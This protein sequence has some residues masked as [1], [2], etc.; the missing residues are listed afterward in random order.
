MGGGVDAAQRLPEALGRA[1]DIHRPD[2]DVGRDALVGGPIL[3]RPAV[4]GI[5]AAC[6]DN[7]GQAG[8]MRGL[9][10]VVAADHVP[11]Q[12]G[13]LPVGSGVWIGRQMYL[14]TDW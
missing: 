4:D 1:V 14:C 13:G 3:L 12:Q 8:L 2:R 10:A 5:H 7:A 6:K 11:W 9:E